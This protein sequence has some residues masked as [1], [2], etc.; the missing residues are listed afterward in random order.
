MIGSISLLA[1][2]EASDLFADEN[3]YWRFC[4]EHANFQHRDADACEFILHIGGSCPAG[5]EESHCHYAA[6]KRKMF[7]YGCTQE[8]IFA[9]MEAKNLGAARV[10]FYV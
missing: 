6:T 4:V 2:V 8:F 7:E 1:E 9:Y 3:I 10:L 5:C